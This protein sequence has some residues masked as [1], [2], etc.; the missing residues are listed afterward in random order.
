M[1]PS[2]FLKLQLVLVFQITDS[3]SESKIAKRLKMYTA[4]VFIKHLDSLSFLT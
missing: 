1:M 4:K 2:S 3:V